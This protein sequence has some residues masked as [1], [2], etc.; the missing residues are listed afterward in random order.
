MLSR[1]ETLVF[2]NHESLH[3]HDLG[4]IAG[5][6]YPVITFEGLQV[7]REVRVGIV[8]HGARLAVVVGGVGI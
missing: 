2:L 7:I 3:L 5:I 8:L 4:R 6:L 1:F